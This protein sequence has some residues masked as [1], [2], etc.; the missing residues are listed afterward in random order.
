MRISMLHRLIATDCVEEM[1][2]Y[3]EHVD[4][5]WSSLVGADTVTMKKID[6]D[7][8]D[9]LQLLAPGKSRADKSTACGLVLSGRAFSD[10]SE[11]ERRSI[12]SRLE[13]FEG[14]VP[15]LYTFF[16]D[17]KYL[18]NCAQCVKRLFGP[19]NESIWNTMKHM[20]HG[21]PDIEE[22]CLIQTSECTVRHQRAGSAERL[23]LG[24]RQVWLYAMRN[25]TLM[26]P[27]PK[28][29]DDLLAKPNR[30]MAD[31]RTIYD[32]ADLARRL[33]F[34]SPEIE[35]IVQGSPDRQ[36]ARNA[37]LQA[38]KP[39][40]FRYDPR[41]FDALV[42]RITECFSAAIPCEPER[43]PELLADSTVK[44]RARCGTPQKRTHKQDNLHL[45]IDYLHNDEVTISQTITSFFVRRCVY[46]AFFGK[47]WSHNRRHAIHGG[48]PRRDSPPPSPLFVRDDSISP[49]LDTSI[50]AR[51]AETAGQ[52]GSG[53]REAL[54]GRGQPNV[55][56][57]PHQVQTHEMLRCRT[58]KMQKR[59]PP[60]RYEP[61]MEL[62]RLSAGSTNDEMTD[63]DRSNLLITDARLSE[64]PSS[65]AAGD[66][67]LWAPLPDRGSPV[68][69][70][71]ERKER[72]EVA[73]S[74]EPSDEGVSEQV[75]PLGPVAQDSGLIELTA[76]GVVAP[77]Q[78][79]GEAESEQS[80]SSSC[81]KR[82]RGAASSENLAPT[83]QTPAEEVS[84]E[85]QRDPYWDE[86]DDRHL[87]ARE[88]QDRL[89]ELERELLEHKLD[90]SPTRPQPAPESLSQGHSL[91]PEP[92]A[93]TS[94]VSSSYSRS[95]IY[96]LGLEQE[97]PGSVAGD[98][99]ETAAAVQNS[100]RGILEGRSSAAQRERPLTQLDAGKLELPAVSGATSAPG[101][102]EGSASPSPAASAGP[103]LPTGATEERPPLTT[104]V[105]VSFWSFERGDWRLTNV[106]RVDPSDPS[107]VERVAMKYMWK[108]YSLYDLNMQSVSPAECFHAATVDG[109]NRIFVISEDEEK[110]LV[111]QGQLIKDRRLLSSRLLNRDQSAT[112][113][114]T[115]VHHPR[116]TE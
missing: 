101:I 39:H 21:S 75:A 36:I 94:P 110:K 49:G 95:D 80:P 26:P 52:R 8:V 105:E 82:L 112:A 114:H 63:D 115:K 42:D 54:T 20:F 109:N 100:D 67:V 102:P 92:Q 65:S 103:A 6:Q 9:N 73:A 116:R 41:G 23:D 5:F 16:E 57:P 58:S 4:E 68:H 43:S 91:A 61:P 45:F 97:P 46:F 87:R 32:L 44:A 113:T 64:S 79:T 48:G 3:L 18:E 28:N 62:D 22:E 72:T 85:N 88:E 81:P 1:I 96:Q 69:D 106:V 47:P 55:R 89:E 33:G 25:Y 12:W 53:P 30:A 2:T 40:H 38:R 74:R 70:R 93:L 60:T 17:F 66:M 99:L 77:D 59:R 14:L 24:Y 78:P 51:P 104:P 35:S 90:L 50:T 29:D 37:L 56:E 107:T 34:R 84:A 86:Y 13:V 15:S 10:F 98:P 71:A 108:G 19:V 111:A 11:A 83:Y 27:D 31:A 76:P 7:T